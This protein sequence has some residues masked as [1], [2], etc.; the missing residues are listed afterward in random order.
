MNRNIEA[1]LD[2][3]L[4]ARQEQD[5]ARVR[6]VISVFLGGLTPETLYA[7]R[8]PD[9]LRPR[10]TEFLADQPARTLAVIERWSKAKKGA[11]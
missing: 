3:L 7:C 5:A 8:E 2:R 11:K 4:E 9:A 1:R 10:L 6:E